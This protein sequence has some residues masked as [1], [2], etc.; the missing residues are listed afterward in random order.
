MRDGGDE[1]KK[2]LKMKEGE[3]EDEEE[4]DEEKEEEEEQEEEEEEEEKEED[5]APLMHGWEI[6][7]STH[8]ETY[9]GI[10]LL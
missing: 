4:D 2:W 1:E 6:T 3:D 7:S 8:Y 5:L 9:F 10:S